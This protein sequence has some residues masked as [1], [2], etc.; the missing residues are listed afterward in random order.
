MNLQ[1]F[2]GTW[3]EIQSHAAELVGHRVRVTVLDEEREPENDEQQKRLRE[4]LH[5]KLGVLTGLP[6][7]LS[8]NTGQTFA[9]LVEEKY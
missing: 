3:E 6:A 9:K 1:T 2:E 5:R 8:E 4:R 7:D